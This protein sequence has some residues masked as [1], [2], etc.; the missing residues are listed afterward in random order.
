VDLREAKRYAR[1]RAGLSQHC[2][3]W[4]I[5]NMGRNDGAVEGALV[6]IGSEA[7]LKEAVF[8]LHRVAYQGSVL[9]FEAWAKAGLPVTTSGSI[10]PAELYQ[11]MQTGNA[12]IILD[13][14]MPYEWMALRIGT[15]VNLPI[16]Q[17]AELSGKLDP[18]LPVVAVCNSAYRSSLAVGSC[19]GKDSKTWRAWRVAAPRG[20]TLAILFMVMK[21][22][23]HLRTP[24]PHPDRRADFT[25]RPGTAD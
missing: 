23:Q 19:S 24:A 14:R 21:I 11:Q 18:N 5:G 9:P 15:V 2:A 20:L 22:R 7:E 12:P 6:L 8:R 25:R 1:A 13:V 4:S 16:N 10:T 3:A 17:L